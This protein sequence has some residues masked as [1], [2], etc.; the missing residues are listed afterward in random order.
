MKVHLNPHLNEID[1]RIL[2]TVA[3]QAPS[4]DT[5]REKRR[6]ASVTRFLAFLN[7]NAATASLKC[8]QMLDF[9]EDTEGKKEKESSLVQL[10]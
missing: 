10:G 6:A 5:N 7:K 8:L 2:T 3:L 4:G 9:V 1:F